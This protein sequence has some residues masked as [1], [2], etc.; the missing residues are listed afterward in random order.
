MKH[1]DFFVRLDVENDMDQE[2]VGNKVMS[3]LDCNEEPLSITR[4]LTLP[5]VTARPRR[6]VK[7]LVDFSKFQS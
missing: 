1:K 4:F 2:E 5:K 3:K 7:A 6:R